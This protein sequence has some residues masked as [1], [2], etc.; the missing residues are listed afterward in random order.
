MIFYGVLL[1]YLI[2]FSIK[3]VAFYYSNLSAILADVF[4]SIV[5]ISL[6]LILLLASR[7]SK[8]VAD[9][10]HPH[11][12]GLVKN[13]ASLAASIAFITLLCF[14][15]LKEGWDRIV[16][17]KVYENLDVAF[18]A[19]FTVLCLL[20]STTL[21]LREQKG[22]LG[23]TA[24]YETLN[25]SLSTLSAILGIILVSHGFAIFDGIATIII[26]LLIAYNSSKLFLENVRF[27]LGLSPS[28]EFYSRVEKSVKSVNGV[29]GVHDM[30]AIYTAENEIHLD[31]HV[32][33]DGNMKVDE[34]DLIARGIV[35]NLRKDFPEIKH[36][37][38]HF[39][40]HFGERRKIYDA[41]S[42]N[43]S[44]ETDC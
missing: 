6:I 8:K 16:N 3:L 29:N 10:H 14:E 11:G 35:E 32:T 40:P 15:L 36:V 41:Q 27:L 33:I 37:S 38:I 7:I 9:N 18:F 12:H 17:P 43:R 5:D 26:A 23:K 22:I 19:E 44:K 2:T 28:E 31:L 39:C 25:D 1:V 30:L 21:F 24:M 42:V 20:L 4:H 13:I 34:A